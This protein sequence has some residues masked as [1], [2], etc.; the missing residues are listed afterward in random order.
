M[1]QREVTIAVN[2]ARSRDTL[3][4]YGGAWFT[5]TTALFTASL[6]P[7]LRRKLPMG[8]FLPVFV[9]SL[10]VG[11]L[12]DAAYGTKV[13]RITNEAEEI[14]WRERW[15]LVPVQ[16]VPAVE[17][18]FSNDDLRR[19]RETRTVE[20]VWPK[21]LPVPKTKKAETEKEEKCE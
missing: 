12:A 10:A 20:E 18:A 5:Y 16:Q 8:A 3:Q 19:A 6:F 21:W 11:N 4:I 7:N 14:I 1:L 13:Q 2:I 9:G 17:K 15:R